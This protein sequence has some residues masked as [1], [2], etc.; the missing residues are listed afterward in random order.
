MA[1]LGVAA[2]LVVAVNVVFVWTALSTNDAVVVSYRSE[3]R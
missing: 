3:A 2:M 1:G